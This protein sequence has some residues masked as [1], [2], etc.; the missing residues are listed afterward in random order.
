MLKQN[1]QNTENQFANLK[2]HRPENMFSFLSNY[3]SAVSNNHNIEFKKSIFYYIQNQVSF[4]H[5]SGTGLFK[6][7]FTKI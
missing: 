4:L 7:V 5:Q 1:T 2:N 6:K 3:N